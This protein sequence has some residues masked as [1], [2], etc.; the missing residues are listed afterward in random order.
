MN[1]HT[2][3]KDFLRHDA[4]PVAQFIKYVFSGGLATATHIV[5]FFFCG[6]LLWPCLTHDD[7]LVKLFDIGITETLSVQ[8]RAWHAGYC[9]T[10]GFFI[11]NSVCYVLNRLFVFKPGRHHWG[12]EFLLFF[13]VAGISM[14]LG[15]TL[16][17]TLITLWEVQTTWAFGGNILISLCINFIMRKF[18]VFAS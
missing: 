5:V 8:Q 2:K 6:W 11:S 4:H 16:Q 9:N 13:A 7:I 15:T 17:T 14:V 3:L 1:F 18:V 10:L 12:V